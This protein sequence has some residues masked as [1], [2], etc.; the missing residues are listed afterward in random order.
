LLLFFTKK[1]LEKAFADCNKKTGEINSCDKLQ[2]LQCTEKNP[3]TDPTN[4]SFQK[5][6]YSLIK[7]QW[8][9]YG[10]DGETIVAEFPVTSLHS[11]F[12]LVVQAR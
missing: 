6:A 2:I 10:F 12:Y 1:E 7:P 9:S 4:N 8:Y 3:D 5:N 11:E